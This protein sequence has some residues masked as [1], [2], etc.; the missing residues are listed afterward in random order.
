MVGLRFQR[1]TGL[2]RKVMSPV[3]A[4]VCPFVTGSRGRRWP[5]YSPSPARLTAIEKSPR[6]L[7][8]RPLT[9]TQT[10][11]SLKGQSHERETAR[12]HPYSS[13]NAALAWRRDADSLC[14]DIGGLG[15]LM[16]NIASKADIP[17]PARQADS[18]G[19]DGAGQRARV[20]EL[21]HPNLGDKHRRPLGVVPDDASFASFEAEAVMDPAF[22]WRRIVGFAAEEA[23]ESVIQIA[24]S[25]F[26][27]DALNRS[28]PLDLIAQGGQL[29][30]LGSEGNPFPG[31]GMVL[32]PVPLTLLQSRIVDQSAHANGL[33]KQFGLLWRRIKAIAEA[34]KHNAILPSHPIC[35][36][37]TP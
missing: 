5:G 20:A 33:R 15:G 32:P 21:D 6:D 26:L 3:I 28:N 10:P 34:A 1:H 24:Q 7:S 37:I 16:L 4:A 18:D 9:H 29:T 25:L 8:L 36:R 27:G 17:M 22:A 14:G 2:R 13:V 31:D 30:A 11:S 19:L 12:D 23:G 35:A